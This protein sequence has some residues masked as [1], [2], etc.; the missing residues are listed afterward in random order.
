MTLRRKGARVREMT[1]D[2]E[3]TI[4]NVV[5]NSGT[6]VTHVK[7]NSFGEPIDGTATVWPASSSASTGCLGT[8]WPAS[9]R[10]GRCPTIRRPASASAKPD[11]LRLRHHEPDGL[12]RQRPH[13]PDRSHGRRRIPRPRGLGQRGLL[14]AN[15]AHYLGDEGVQEAIQQDGAVGLPNALSGSGGTQITAETAQDLTRSQQVNAWY[16]AMSQEDRDAWNYAQ[17]APQQKCDPNALAEPGTGLMALEAV[18]W[19]GGGPA[20]GRAGKARNRCSRHR[21][22]SLAA[23]TATLAETPEGTALLNEGSSLLPETAGPSSEATGT[24]LSQLENLV[25]ETAN[26]SESGSTA[27]S[28]GQ[29]ALNEVQSVAQSEAQLVP[30]TSAARQMAVDEA[31]R[32]ARLT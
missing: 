12:V 4:R 17:L 2:Q 31:L 14:T 6:L 16:G 3:G 30:S 19:F 10:P 7:Y 23:G 13:R 29:A 32:V 5:N 24:V 11:R 22:R 1:A 8:P 27:T 18:S 15:V 26:L 20:F 25:P 28:E 9:T 21:R